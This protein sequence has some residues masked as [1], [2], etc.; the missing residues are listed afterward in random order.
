MSDK[1]QYARRARDM[2]AIFSKLSD[3]ILSLQNVYFDRGYND[4]GDDE[5]IDAGVE[6]VDVTGMI[7]F[8]GALDTFLEANRGY[9][10][11]MRN[12]L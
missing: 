7:T 11:Q 3:D 8:A 4:G 9:L 6:A 2:A 1:L 10:S 12:D 5:L